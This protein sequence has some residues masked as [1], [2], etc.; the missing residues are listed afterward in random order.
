MA[1]IVPRP[2]ISVTA[3]SNHSGIS[4]ASSIFPDEQSTDPTSPNDKSFDFEKCGEKSAGSEGD[5]DV[6]TGEDVVYRYLEFDTEIPTPNGLYQTSKEGQKPPPPQPDLGKY[7]SPFEW[8]EKRKNAIIWIS[9]VITSLTAFTAGAYSPGVGQMTEEWNVS[10][11]AA[12]AGITTFCA[13]MHFPFSFCLSSI[14]E[15]L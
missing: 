15:E 2:S 6:E 7:T 12:L 3:D 5:E 4:V 13:G 14:S 9:C 11:V 1:D 8:P 10:S